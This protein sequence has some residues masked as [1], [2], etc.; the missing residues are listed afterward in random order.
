MLNVVLAD[1]WNVGSRQISWPPTIPSLIRWCWTEISSETLSRYIFQNTNEL[2]SGLVD[3]LL[4]WGNHPFN[5]GHNQRHRRSNMQYFPIILDNLLTTRNQT[6][7]SPP[8]LRTRSVRHNTTIPYIS[9][10]YELI[11]QV[12]VSKQPERKIVRNGINAK[13]EIIAG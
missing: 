9:L 7:D 11:P 1:L 4:H 2:T 12:V 3:R 6:C 8:Q 5:H 10:W 13:P